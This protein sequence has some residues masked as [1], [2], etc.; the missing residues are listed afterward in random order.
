M[1]PD[2]EHILIMNGNT[3]HNDALSYN[4]IVDFRKLLIL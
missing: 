4:N 3:Y 1:S 2:D